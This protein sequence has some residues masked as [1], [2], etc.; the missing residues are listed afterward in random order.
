MFTLIVD[1]EPIGLK[2][3]ESKKGKTK[4]ETQRRWITG[5][6]PQ[7]G[8]RKKLCVLTEAESKDFLQ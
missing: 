5:S 2:G 4:E 8:R 6:K 1:I 7:L 3:K